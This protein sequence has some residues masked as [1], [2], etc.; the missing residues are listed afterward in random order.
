MATEEERKKRKKPE[1]VR[2]SLTDKEYAVILKMR[3]GKFEE[4]AIFKYAM[5]VS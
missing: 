4:K 3:Q 2:L 1:E 5:T